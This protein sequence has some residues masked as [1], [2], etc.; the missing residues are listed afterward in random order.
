MLEAIIM[1][2]SMGL[3]LGAGLAVA[4]KVFYVYVDPL[5]LEIDDALPGANCGGCGKPGCTA[6]AEAIAAGEAAPNSCV[7]AGTDV[8][9]A[10]AAI[11]GVTVEAQE[12][13]IARPGCTYGVA[14]SDQKYIYNGLND[15]RAAVLLSGGMKVCSIG[16]LGLGTCARAC[17]FDA[18]EM[19]PMGLPLVNEKRCT[20]CGT[21]ERVCPKN[22]ITMSSVTR[23][24]MREYT[25]EDCTTPC[26]RACPAGIDIQ[27]YIHQIAVGDYLKAI[28]VIKER[29]PFPA[30]I[31]RICPRPCEQ[32][33]RR[34]FVDEPVAI[35]FLKRYAADYEKEQDK[36]ILPYRAPATGRKVAII[37][38]GVQGLS[39]AFFAARLGHEP[40]VYE[41]GKQPGGLLRNAIATYRLPMEILDWDIDGLR[42]MGVRIE[43][44]KSLGRDFTV[45]ALLKEG[46]GAVFVATGGWDSR[47][48]RGHGPD[49]VHPIPGINLLIDV[50]KSPDCITCGSNVVICGGG[51]LALQAA[52]IC[53]KQSP[54]NITIMFRENRETIHL[55]EAEIETLKKEGV[56]IRF[57]TAVGKLSGR[58]DR[59]TELESVDLLTQSAA[60][61]PA[62]TLI[63][64]S[65]RQPEFIFIKTPT[66]ETDQETTGP[67]LWQAFER[68][69]EPAHKNEIGL[70]APGDANT[71]FTAAIKAIAA[72]RRAAASIH[73]AMYGLPL[74]LPHKAITPQ[75]FLQNVDSVNN[76]P[77]VS[78]QIMP[79]SSPQEVD[80]GHELEKGF[81]QETA[82]KE[83]QRCLQCGLIC[84]EHEGNRGHAAG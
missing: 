45:A 70:F 31:G 71:D 16:C 38:A 52:R 2:G 69:K 72:G 77:A 41:A 23:R 42:E 26:Q 61:L 47:L 74:T 67:L 83:A 1:M 75:S 73:Q 78:R 32:D 17:P 22:I 29:N 76:V 34:K 14:A 55:D 4:S 12:P 59:L 48:L 49:N 35:N 66:E 57:A 13:D 43:T 60:T 50:I 79:L 68:V 30:V 6:N 37:G 11:M 80:S 56:T 46:H 15:C 18:I 54:Q 27:E 51:K 81:D 3:L 64:S 20:G 82:K 58:E 84:Y 24:I 33:C 10:I 63:V 19:G 39:T 5:I 28:Q 36:R 7:V 44:E 25:T 9:E 62:D 21:C 65:G 40:I 53:Q 8:I